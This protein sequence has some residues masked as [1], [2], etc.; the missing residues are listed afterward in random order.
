MVRLELQFFGGRGASAGSSA[1]TSA[2]NLSNAIDAYKQAVA[3]RAQLVANK[4]PFDQIQ[5]ALDKQHTAANNMVAQASDTEF[6]AG[7]KKWF[8]E[9]GREEGAKT[10]ERII[11]TL[12]R[13][14]RD[15]SMSATAIKA[16]K[17]YGD[18]VAENV[19]KA[20]ANTG[21]FRV[22][23]ANNNR[24]AEALIRE[25]RRRRG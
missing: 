19:G 13:T 14:K 23:D 12:S 20:L 9:L 24:G 7:A 3:E 2:S 1:G 15:G 16:A 22:N 8:D 6:D 18:D 25:A 10:Q 21:A 5:S 4:A 17:G 11:N